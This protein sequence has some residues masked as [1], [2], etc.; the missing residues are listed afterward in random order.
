MNQNGIHDSDI[1]LV[2]KN[3]VGVLKDYLTLKEECAAVNQKKGM[4]FNPLLYIPIKEPVHSKIIGDF[5]N[6]RGSHGQGPLFL[7]CFL[8][9]FDVP[10]RDLG[11]WQISI[12]TDRVDIRL[13]REESREFPASMILIESKVKDANDM[14]NQIFRY[15]HHQMYRWKPKH[16]QDEETRRSFRL[17]YLTTDKS[18]APEQ[19]S[20]ERP[21]DWDDRI[22]EHLTVPLKCE[23]FSL[24]ELIEL[25]TKALEQVPDT[26]HRLHVFLHL[27]KELWL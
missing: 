16:W 24:R 21:A 1:A 22:N 17:I 15:W 11:T 7:Q 27:Y 4:D 23:T 3:I 6:P 20:L 13:W 25:W 8:E 2:C 19:H 14:R 26:N 12:E 5:L 18:K 10:Q 9:R